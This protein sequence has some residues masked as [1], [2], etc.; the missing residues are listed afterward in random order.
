M[1]IAGDQRDQ[2]SAADGS[3]EKRRRAAAWH[4][5]EV[6][7][8]L[9]SSTG[10]RPAFDYELLRLFAQ[11]RLAASL[12]ILLLVGTEVIVTFPPER[13]MSSLA[14]LAEPAPSIAPL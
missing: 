4:V 10:T 12:V 6:R 14:P 11:N 3:S 13:V 7:S 2:A 1:S 9:T 5:R 8:R